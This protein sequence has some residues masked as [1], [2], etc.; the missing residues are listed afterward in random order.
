VRTTRSKLGL[1][2]EARIAG[3]VIVW[4]SEPGPGLL[5]WVLRAYCAAAM[6]MGMT[7]LTIFYMARRIVD[8]EIEPKDLA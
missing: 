7:E 3:T 2:A 4:A 1:Y 6:Q 5:W 8:G